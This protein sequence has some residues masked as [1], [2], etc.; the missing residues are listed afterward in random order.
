MQAPL[1]KQNSDMCL[2]YEVGATGGKST[3]KISTGNW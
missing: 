3:L 2:I 1:H